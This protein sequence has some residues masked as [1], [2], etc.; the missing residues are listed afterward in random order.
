MVIMLR[1]KEIL[2]WSLYQA[3]QYGLLL[4]VGNKTMNVK[5][6]KLSWK[7]AKMGAVKN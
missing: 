5:L 6:Q 3:M 7:S 4:V 1:P 2:Y